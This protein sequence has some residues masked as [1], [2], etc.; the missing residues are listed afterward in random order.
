MLEAICLTLFIPT[1]AVHSMLMLLL[2][3]FS[4]ALIL[5]PLVQSSAASNF[6]KVLVM[7]Y[8]H[9]REHSIDQNIVD[10]NNNS[11]INTKGLNG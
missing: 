5:V 3:L 2:L 10:W 1:I 4:L 8:N 9:W 7:K 11:R 6:L